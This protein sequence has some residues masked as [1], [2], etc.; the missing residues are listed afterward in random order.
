MDQSYQ[1]ARYLNGTE[2]I[3]FAQAMGRM[4]CNEYE[5]VLA[6]MF[7]M[8]CVTA[9][10]VGACMQSF[11]PFHRVYCKANEFADAIEAQEP[12]F[13]AFLRKHGKQARSMFAAGTPYV[14]CSTYLCIRHG[15]T[16]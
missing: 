15:A 11:W 7:A 5:Y 1:Q 2:Q 3:H 4:R 13:A 12:K 16:N 10:A 6:C 8:C 14:A 9:R